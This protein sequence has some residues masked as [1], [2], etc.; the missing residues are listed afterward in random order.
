[1]KKCIFSLCLLYSINAFAQTGKVGI[2]TTN[3]Q[4][5]LHVADSA[6]LFTGPIPVPATTPHNPPASGPGTRMMWYPQKAA[7]RVGYV[8]NNNWDKDSIGR[9][10]FA[11]G[12]DSKAL[13]VGGFASGFYTNANGYTSTSLGYATTANGIASSSLGYATAANGVASSSMGSY[14]IARSDYSLVAG[15]YND[16]T[17]TNRLF[18]IG[19]G[20]D[21]NARSNAITVLTNGNTGLGTTIPTARLHV[22][23]SAVLFAG[24][25]FANTTTL[26]NPPASGPGTRMMWY[27]QKAAFRVGVVDNNDWNKDSIGRY[28]FATGGDAKAFGVGSFASGLYSNAHGIVSTSMGELTQSL[29]NASVSM[30]SN[31]KASGDYSTSL[32]YGT[33]AN[34][35]ISTS[36]GYGTIANGNY[37]TSMGLYTQANGNISTSSGTYTSANGIASTTMGSYTIARSNN[38]LVVGTYN[39]TSNTNTLF[40]VGNGAADYARSNALTVL[41]DGNIGIGI[42]S[43]AFPLNFSTALGDKISLWGN[44]AGG[45]HYGVG[46]Q[47]GLLQIHGDEAISNIAFGYGRSNSFTERMR[48]VN[49]GADGVVLSGRLLLKNGTG[50]IT[51]GPG[52]W[53]YKTDNSVQLGFIGAENNQNIGFYGGP[54]GWGFTYDAIHSRV[55]IGTSNPSQAL[56]V[57]G[58][59]LASGT[60]TPSD[61][62]YK[63]DIVLIEQPINKINQLNGVTYHYRS[64]DFPDMKFSDQTQVGLIAQ[65]VEKI[66]PQLVFTDDKGYKAVDYVKLIPLLVEGLKAQQIQIDELKKLVEKQLSK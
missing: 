6:V 19:N 46:V 54:V 53:I 13:G 47:S 27:P 4:A 26:Y 36:L 28:S 41:A 58:N 40:E 14:T 45:N 49:S 7:L 23:D 65:D 55:G 15:T 21:N 8:S 5:M 42:P 61:A 48:I 62:R 43:P 38:S 63:K 11:T 50:S 25:L 3:P 35:Y 64:A 33:R 66:F 51:D 60:I 56:Q 17:N 59:I 31:T 12:A 34:G 44:A 1:M 30:G 10:S 37:S 24:P 39:D 9:Y 20:T 18:E 52:V 57:V 32:G 22:V 29:G 16:T 2:G